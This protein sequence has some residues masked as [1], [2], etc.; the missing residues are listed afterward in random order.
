MRGAQ[1]GFGR[2]NIM[3]ENP[4]FK[5]NLKCCEPEH[6]KG[7]TRLLVLIWERGAAFKAALAARVNRDKKLVA[8]GSDRMRQ[9]PME[10]SLTKDVPNFPSCCRQGDGEFPYLKESIKR[11]YRRTKFC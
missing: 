4:L 9:A 3:S 8:Q 11:L 7:S 10:L 6:L 2:L 1:T 5:E